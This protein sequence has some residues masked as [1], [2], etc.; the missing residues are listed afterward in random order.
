[1]GKE[2]TRTGKKKKKLPGKSKE[3]RVRKKLEFN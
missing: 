2:R 3:N 1:M